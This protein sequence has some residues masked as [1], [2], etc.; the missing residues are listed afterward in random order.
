HSHTLLHGAIRR[1]GRIVAIDSRSWLV[2]QREI[3][4]AYRSELAR[5][6]QALGFAVRRSTGRGQRYFELDA[7]PQPLLDRWSS[8]HH[9]VQ[10]AI[11]QRLTDQERELE[12]VIAKGGSGA[13][14]A[15]MQLE[16]LRQTGQL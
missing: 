8:R 15:G 6:L 1:D 14:E 7:V 11:R 12:A 4:A 3:G 16:L 2:H 9:Q 10:A 5:E 13:A